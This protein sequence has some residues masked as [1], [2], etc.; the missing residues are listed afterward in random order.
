LELCGLAKNTVRALDVFKAGQLDD[1]ALV[2]LVGWSVR[3]PNWS[4]RL[5]RS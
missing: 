3:A 1:D 5:R 2:A 4:M